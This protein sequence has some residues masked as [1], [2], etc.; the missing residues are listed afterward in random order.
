M[1]AILEAA[2]DM[3]DVRLIDKKT[4]RGYERLCA[5]QEVSAE[6]VARIRNAVNAS[7][8]CGLICPDTSIGGKATRRGVLHGK[9]A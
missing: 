6:D 3:A 9:K 8:C 2:Q 1:G 4:M 7:Q 5:V